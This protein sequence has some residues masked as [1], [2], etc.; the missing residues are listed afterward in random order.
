MAKPDGLSSSSSSSKAK[1]ALS[2]SSFSSASKTNGG[3]SVSSSSGGGGGVSSAMT[4]SEAA[5]KLKN[6]KG[7]H[8]DDGGD[9]ESESGVQL[10]LDA[11]VMTF[12]LES[13][14]AEKHD[15]RVVSQLQEFV[16]RYVTEILLDAQEYSLHADKQLTMEL[17]EKRNSIPLPPI[18]NEYGVRLPPLQYQLVTQEI[19][20]QDQ[21]SIGGS[22]MF[23]LENSDDALLVGGAM[24]S[25]R[26]PLHPQ[27]GSEGSRNKRVA[28]HQIPVNIN[29]R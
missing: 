18:S 29:Q 22:G 23:A 25:S 27:A 11:Q 24:S 6:L 15:P 17:A 8:E 20:R 21:T 12:V 1:S 26:P 19:D 2:S 7:I 10:P 9:D 14:G 16:H 3:A 5:L 4:G 28:R 13:M